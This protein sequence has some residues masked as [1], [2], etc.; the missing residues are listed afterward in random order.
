MLLQVKD[1]HL[2]TWSNTIFGNKPIDKGLNIQESWTAL[3][4]SNQISKEMS[5][6]AP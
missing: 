5:E 4:A 6:E 3:L 1:K 2:S